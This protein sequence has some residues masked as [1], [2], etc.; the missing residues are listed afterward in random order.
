M[1]GLSVWGES[2]KAERKTSVHK[3]RCEAETGEV[4]IF[5]AIS[6]SANIARLF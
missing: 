6:V 3:P 2:V 1:E 4:I 5:T